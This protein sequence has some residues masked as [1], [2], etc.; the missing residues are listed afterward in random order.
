MFYVSRI[1]PFIG[2][3]FLGNPDNYRMLGV[4]T[5]EFNNCRRMT[6]ALQ[7]VG[8]EVDYREFFYGCMGV[9]QAL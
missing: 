4:Y 1:I 9:R 2:R 5:Q 3:L 8:L 7:D 6:D